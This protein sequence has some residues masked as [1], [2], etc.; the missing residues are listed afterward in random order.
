[1]VRLRFVVVVPQPQHRRT[2]EIIH[3]RSGNRNFVGRTNHSPD[4]T[5]GKTRLD[6]S[7]FPAAG[8]NNTPEQPKNRIT[9]QSC[10]D[11]LLCSLCLAHAQVLLGNDPFHFYN[12]T[13]T[14]ITSLVLKSCHKPL[15]ALLVT[16]KIDLPRGNACL[17]VH[18]VKTFQHALPLP[19]MVKR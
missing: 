1:M 5:I 2:V 4:R 13:Q 10:K 14:V 15:F 12:D 9:C 17:Q 16:R 6:R 8:G 3:G 19:Q 7:S 18:Q 11:T